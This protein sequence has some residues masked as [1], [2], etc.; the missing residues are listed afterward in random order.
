MDNHKQRKE[1]FNLALEKRYKENKEKKKSILAQL[2][3][4]TEQAA[5]NKEVFDALK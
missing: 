1:T 2:K 5:I 4:L 3:A